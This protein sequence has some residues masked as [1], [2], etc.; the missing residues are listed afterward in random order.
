[1]I[2]IVF[3]INFFLSPRTEVVEVGESTKVSVSL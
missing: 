2:L 3:I 1:M